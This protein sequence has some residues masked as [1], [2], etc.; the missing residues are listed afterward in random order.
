MVLAELRPKYEEC[1]PTARGAK[2]S[3]S[4]SRLS[5]RVQAS[6]AKADRA[7]IGGPQYSPLN[8]KPSNISPYY[9]DLQD[10]QSD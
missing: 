1:S 10:L 8:P 2:W 6:V 7:K 9:R 4:A 5:K 3:R